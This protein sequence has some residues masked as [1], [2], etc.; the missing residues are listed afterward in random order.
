MGNENVTVKNLTVFHVD[1]ENNLLYIKGAVPGA[2]RSLV[3]I[4]KGLK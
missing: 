4:K 2:K 3:Y 1:A